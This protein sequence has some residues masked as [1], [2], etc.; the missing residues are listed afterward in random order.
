MATKL[1]VVPPP[2]ELTPLEFLMRFVNDPDPTMSEARIQAA[3]ALLPYMHKAITPLC[4]HVPE[5]DD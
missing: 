1:K 3:I 5:D 2:P 4:S